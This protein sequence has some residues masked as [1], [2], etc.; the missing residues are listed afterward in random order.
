MECQG[1]SKNIKKCPFFRSTSPILPLKPLECKI[2]ISIINIIV[3]INVVLLMKKIQ[4]SSINSKKIG[5]L[6]YQNFLLS[7]GT[8]IYLLLE[9]E[10]IWKN[11]LVDSLSIKLRSGTIFLKRFFRHWRTCLN[12]PNHKQ[13]QPFQSQIMRVYNEK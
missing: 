5:L 11:I 9:Q 10:S 12:Y 3:L 4:D 1:L 7:C 2:F 13:S 8:F 6:Y